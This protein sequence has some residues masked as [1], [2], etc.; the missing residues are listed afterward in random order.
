MKI[1]RSD[2]VDLVRQRGSST[3]ADRAG[4]YIPP[5]W[6]LTE[7]PASCADSAWTSL[8]TQFSSSSTGRASTSHSAQQPRIRA[9]PRGR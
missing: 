8:V 1:N 3:Q 5:S 6:I 4:R 7:T 9:T 2:L